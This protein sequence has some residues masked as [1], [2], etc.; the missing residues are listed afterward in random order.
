MKAISNRSNNCSFATPEDTL[1]WKA[2]SNVSF[3]ASCKAGTEVISN[4][5]ACGATKLKDGKHLGCEVKTTPRRNHSDTK[6]SGPQSQKKRKCFNLSEKVALINYVR[7][8]PNVGY[9]KV[10]E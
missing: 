10:A 3:P 1:G 9:R 2:G 4:D 8:H 5:A 6:P 7:N